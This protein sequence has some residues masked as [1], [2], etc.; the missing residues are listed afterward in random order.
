MKPAHHRPLPLAQAVEAFALDRLLGDHFDD[1]IG[2]RLD[3]D[4]AVLVFDGD[5]VCAGDLDLLHRGVA[6]GE[7]WARPRQGMYFFD[8]DISMGGID[9]HGVDGLIVLGDL[10]CDSLHLREELLYVQGDLVARSAVRASA[11]QDWHD[12]MAQTL[13]PLYVH[14]KGATTSPVVQ[15]WHMPLRHLAWTAGSGAEE[16]LVLR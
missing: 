16:P 11:S 6:F 15:T 8:G 9:L 7:P 13:G 2:D 3:E 5:T 1:L 10:R 12:A 14:V 4:D